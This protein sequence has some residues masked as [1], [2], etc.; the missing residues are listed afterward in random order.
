M[1]H[2]EG[3]RV[4]LPNEPLLSKY[5]RLNDLVFQV[6]I[7]AYKKSIWL[8]FSTDNVFDFLINGVGIIQT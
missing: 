6:L 8:N 2:E 7:N 4:G 3:G 5:S 1:G